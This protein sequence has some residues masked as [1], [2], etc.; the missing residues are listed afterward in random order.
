MRIGA[1]KPT[2]FLRSHR[3]G[4]LPGRWRSADQ[5]KGDDKDYG[6]RYAGMWCHVRNLKWFGADIF[7]R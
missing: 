4:L 7:S 1:F 2:R 5:G 6:A 3:V